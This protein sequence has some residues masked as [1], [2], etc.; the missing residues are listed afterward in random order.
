MCNSTGP[1]FCITLIL[2]LNVVGIANIGSGERLEN[3]Y[4]FLLASK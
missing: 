3:V 2:V 4:I 1:L